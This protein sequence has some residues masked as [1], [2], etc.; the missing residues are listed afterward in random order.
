MNKDQLEIKAR[1][2]SAKQIILGK[3]CL[4]L[5]AYC[6]FALNAT[7]QKQ[8]PELWNL[9]VHDDAKVLKQ[10]TAEILE[11]QLKAYEDSTSNQVAILIV[12]S[13]DGEVIEDYSIRV[14]EKWKLGTKKNDN[15]V[16]ILVAI[17]DHKM[18]IEVGQ[19]LE[20]V[21]TDALCNRII[22]NEMAPEFRRNDYDAGMTS[23][24]NA[25]IS[26]IG[27][28]YKAED[29]GGSNDLD[30]MNTTTKIVIGSIVFIFLGIFATL[31]LFS[32]GGMTWV[33]YAFLIPFYAAFMGLLISWWF[34]FGYLIVYPLLRLWVVKSGK[35]LLEWQSSGGGGSGGGSSSG[36]SWSSSGSSWSS[37]NSGRSFSGGGGSFGGGGSSGSW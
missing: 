5:F 28:E 30:S 14:V 20:G 13:L 3:S 35:K 6:L 16:L 36:S 29:D 10:E 15:G 17:D 23:A 1:L 31:G 21:L 8:I 12:Q 4:L 32:K 19:G 33:L 7:A 27:G 18:R 2:V 34:F 37:S 25:V 24:V 26:G 22:R 11:K 9:R